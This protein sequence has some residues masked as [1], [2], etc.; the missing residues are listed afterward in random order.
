MAHRR[1]PIHEPELRQAKGRAYAASCNEIATKYDSSTIYQALELSQL[2][3]AVHGLPYSPGLKHMKEFPPN[4]FE[5]FCE[6][7]GNAFSIKLRD[8]RTGTIA[9]WPHWAG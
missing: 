4:R 3:Y 2:A 6:A 8:A 5:W 7:K 9:R 1:T